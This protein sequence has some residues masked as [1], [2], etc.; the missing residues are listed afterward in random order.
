MINFENEEKSV[1]KIK[2]KSLKIKLL[3]RQYKTYFMHT[4]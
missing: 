1:N 2:I 4:Q 3:P